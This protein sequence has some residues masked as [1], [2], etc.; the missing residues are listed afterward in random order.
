MSPS[1]RVMWDP[2][3]L[4]LN[5]GAWVG[6]I[7]GDPAE[8]IDNFELG[9][10]EPTASNTGFR[11]PEI[12]LANYSGDITN[13]PGGLPIEKL[14]I[15][16]KVRLPATTTTTIKD[17]LLL[18]QTQD[19]NNNAPGISYYNIADGTPTATSGA[20]IVTYEHCEI[21][22]SV[23]NY[24]NNGFKGGNIV[25]Y[26]CKGSG[27]TDFASVHGSG[28]NGGTT[29]SVKLHGCYADQFYF[30]PDPNQ[31]DTNGVT[32]P[33]F[34]QAQGL[35]SVLEIIGCATG[36]LGRPRTSF[37]LLQSDAGAYGAVKI[38]YNWIRSYE[39]SGTGINVPIANTN[40]ASFECIGNRAS[41]TGIAPRIRLHSTI[42]SAY[43]ATI[44]DNIEM[45]TG[46]PLAIA[47]A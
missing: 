30:G 10:T 17:S 31:D 19:I 40:F 8:P 14:A 3:A 39:L 20:G 24:K 34:C 25:A 6:G 32:H 1:E 9:V 16:G 42:R 38:N 23:A 45:E 36:N 26:R 35:L 43:A 37:C 2:N 11:V 13:L 28:A 5:I 41:T 12:Q 18:G 33:D 21:R 29:K 15:T 7:Y 22:A 44:R 47:N 46:L 4:G 27:L